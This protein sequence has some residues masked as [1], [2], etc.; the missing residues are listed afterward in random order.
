MLST[1][2]LEVSGVT[3]SGV[4]KL[5][6]GSHRKKTRQRGGRG[7]RCE[8]AA[9][10]SPNPLSPCH[11]HRWHTAR[12]RQQNKLFYALSLLLCCVAIS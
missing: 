9:T 8:L 11:G 2:S 7:L 3:G 5:R 6:P 12:Q 10:P 1:Q 4:V